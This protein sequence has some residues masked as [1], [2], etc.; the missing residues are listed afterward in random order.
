MI[1]P[2]YLII[3]IAL[4]IISTILVRT[5]RNFPTRRDVFDPSR[6][7]QARTS[8]IHPASVM[9][10]RQL[11]PTLGPVALLLEIRMVQEALAAVRKEGNLISELNESATLRSKTEK[12]FAE[13]TTRTQNQSELASLMHQRDLVTIMNTPVINAA[14][15][16]AGANKEQLIMGVLDSDAGKIQAIREATVLTKSAESD[17]FIEVLRGRGK[18]SA[19]KAMKELFAEI[20][21]EGKSLFTPG[22]SNDE[23]RQV[24]TE[25]PILQGY[26]HEVFG[27]NEAVAAFEAGELSKHEFKLRIKANLFHNGPQAGF[28]DDLT[29]KFVPGSLSKGVDNAKK[30]FKG[31]VF[32][33]E[34]KNTVVAPKYNGPVSVEGVFHTMAD[35]LSQGTRGGVNKIFKELG[36]SKLD[37]NPQI[38]LSEINGLNNFESLLVQNPQSTI[39]QLEAL[40][41][42]ARKFNQPTLQ[43]IIESAKKRIS[44]EIKYLNGF[45]DREGKWTE[46]HLEVVRSDGGTIKSIIIKR[47]GLDANIIEQSITGQTS[48]KEAQAEI[49]SLLKHEETI[50]GDPFK[51]FGS[52]DR[53]LCTPRTRWPAS[54]PSSVIQACS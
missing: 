38:P 40:E 16:D 26:L 29:T 45:T 39:R 35:R 37:A 50:N 11:F 2:A 21:M 6:D 47:E 52:K 51:E 54:V 32:E 10:L 46:G 34:T 44:D 27:M 31:T 33:G 30:V 17:H 41:N 53:A 19:T 8:V 7:R 49:D 48:A 5:V 42:E 15:R 28:W 9:K 22:L 4:V 24:L 20:G 1:T 18:S 43:A 14:L 36:G 13:A 12:Y 25:Q 3:A 23:I